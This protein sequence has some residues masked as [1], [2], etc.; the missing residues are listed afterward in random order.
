MTRRRFA[1]GIAGAAGL[2]AVTTLFARAAGF[3]RILVFADAV[4]ALG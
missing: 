1:S 4:R 3:A 2:I